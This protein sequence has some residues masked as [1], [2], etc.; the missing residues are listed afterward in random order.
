MTA[1]LIDGKAIAKSIQD[2]VEREVPELARTGRAPGLAVVLVGEDPASQIYVGRK[3]KTCAKLGI[4]SVERML[5]ATVEQAALLEVVDSLNGDDAIDGILVQLPLPKH[6]DSDR[7]L[8]RVRPDKDV[9]GFHPVTVG[10]MMLGRP[11]V[12]PCT[13]AGIMKMLDAIGFT[14]AGKKACIIGRSNIV[15]K[16]MGI[17]LLERHMTVTLCHSRTADLA[18]EVRQADL[19]V[20]AVGVAELVKGE[21]IKPG[22]VVIDVGMNRQGEKL[23]GDVEF[24]AARERASFITPVPGGVGPMTIAMLMSNTL[25]LAKARLTPRG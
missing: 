2:G 20:A 7:I 14:Y 12:R 16:P 10:R 5:P 1:Q 6:L 22:A 11:G 3:I 4:H 17:L 25:A 23:L 9:D 21:W 8:D 24:E 15:G 13:P 18:A 19:V